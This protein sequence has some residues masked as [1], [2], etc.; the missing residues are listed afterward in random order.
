MDYLIS[1]YMLGFILSIPLML[2]GID[3]SFPVRDALLS[4]IF[5]PIWVIPILLYFTMVLV[6]CVILNKTIE[7]GFRYIESKTYNWKIMRFI[8]RFLH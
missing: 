8:E 3:E 4:I 7:E 6:Y 2:L 1:I 5:Y